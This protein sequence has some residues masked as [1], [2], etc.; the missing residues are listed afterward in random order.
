MIAL[1][2]LLSLLPPDLVDRLALQHQVDAKNQVR[3]RGSTVFV[4]ILTSSAS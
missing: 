2:S 3:L 1:D 4:C